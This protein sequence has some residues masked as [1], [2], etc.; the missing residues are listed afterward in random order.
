MKTILN[1][2]LLHDYLQRWCF[3]LSVAKTTMIAFY[4]NNRD[5]QH[6]TVSV[7]GAI[8]SNDDNPIHLGVM[9]DCTL[10]YKQHLEAL[11][12]EVNFRNGFLLCLAGF[13]WGA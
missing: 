6:L 11:Q 8:L 10:T 7:D 12:H 13:N 3:K 1:Q 2:E 4:L 5:S 9:L